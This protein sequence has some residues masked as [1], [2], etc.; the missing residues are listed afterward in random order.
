[1]TAAVCAPVFI[2]GLDYSALFKDWGFTKNPPPNII[3]AVLA[4][5]REAE[6]GAGS[7]EEAISDFAKPPEEESDEELDKLPQIDCLIFGYNKSKQ[8]G[9][10]SILLATVVGGRLSYVGTIYAAEIPS[11]TRDELRRRLPELEQRNP[12]FPTSKTANWLKPVLTCRIAYKEWSKTKMLRQPRFR[13]LTDDLGGHGGAGDR[14]R[15]AAPDAAGPDD[16]FSS[17]SGGSSPRHE[18]TKS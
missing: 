2:G 16:Q 3:Q 18:S 4:Q 5:K 13:R 15:P 7:L 11:A 9:F 10:S 17:E 1:L 8:E 14:A 6:E 12:V